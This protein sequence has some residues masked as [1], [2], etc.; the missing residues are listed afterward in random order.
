[1]PVDPAQL[2]SRTP[3]FD[4]IG[5]DVLEYGDGRAAC[6]IDSTPWLDGAS[7]F[8]I[9]AGTVGL[10][11]SLLAHAA[12]SASSKGYIPVTLTMGL[13]FWRAPVDVG[14]RLAGTAAVEV[15]DDD[16]IL[17]R[18]EMA[19]GGTTVATASL[20]SMLAPVAHGTGRGSRFPGSR[21]P[22]AVELIPVG[23]STSGAVGDPAAVLALPIAASAGLEL[24]HAGYGSVELTAEIGD[25]LART[26][27]VVHGGAVPIV[28]Q[29]A[30][31]A[32][33]ATILP[34]SNAPRRLSL[35]SE[36]LR[37]TPLSHPLTVRSR[38]VHRSRRI[39][40]AHAEILDPQGKPTARIYETAM[41]ETT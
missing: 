28:G 27:G 10:A 39:A 13:D 15:I 19:A 14:V 34:D 33:L 7:D 17:V 2:P 20:R 4:T 21:P 37:P 11:D 5:L 3:F 24:V 25:D 1:M 32:A 41:V 16:L 8:G 36:F 30:I 18:G 35:A 29:V 12:A 31:A 9:H 40:M 22:A 38:V 23:M 6:T 26:M